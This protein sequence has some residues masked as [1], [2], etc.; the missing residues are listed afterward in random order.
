MV[1]DLD[2]SKRGLYKKYAY[3]HSWNI[4]ITPKENTIKTDLV[5]ND[6]DSRIDICLW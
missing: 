6:N 3:Q 4:K 2:V 5:D 1:L